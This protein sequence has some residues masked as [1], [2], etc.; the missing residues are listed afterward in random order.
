MVG[1]CRH[2]LLARCTNRRR[3][4]TY[5][6]DCGID[7]NDG[8]AVRYCTYNWIGL[9]LCLRY[10]LE[11]YICICTT[12]LSTFSSPSSPILPCL[13]VF[14]EV[15]IYFFCNFGFTYPHFKL[16]VYARK[17]KTESAFFYIIFYA[18]GSWQISF[19]LETMYW[20]HYACLRNYHVANFHVISFRVKKKFVETVG[21]R[22]FFNAEI[23][24]T[25][26]W[27]HPF[28]EA[29]DF[30]RRGRVRKSLL[31]PRPPWIWSTDGSLPRFLC[32]IAFSTAVF[33]RRSL[34]SPDMLTTIV[35]DLEDHSSAWNTFELTSRVRTSSEPN[36]FKTAVFVWTSHVLFSCLKIYTV[37]IFSR[38]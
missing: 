21:Q 28:W 16:V 23:S 5:L 10:G 14:F 9:R 12:T 30:E 7:W 2:C 6:P 29:Q 38:V 24:D 17:N 35:W 31:Q 20:A 4:S 34:A 11:V 36:R 13:S 15:A 27:Q 1:M 25:Y 32:T 3:P 26:T 18:H 8:S 22:N 19:I 37:E 33:A